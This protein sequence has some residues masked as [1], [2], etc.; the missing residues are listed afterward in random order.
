[1][2]GVRERRPNVPGQWTK[3][4]KETKLCLIVP[5]TQRLHVQTKP[6]EGPV[7]SFDEIISTSTR[8]S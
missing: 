8:L 3:R 2:C 4:Q 7:R 1:M 6:P 5:C